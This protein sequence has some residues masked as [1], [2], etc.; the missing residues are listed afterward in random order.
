MNSSAP[1]TPLSVHSPNRELTPSSSTGGVGTGTCTTMKHTAQP[2]LTTGESL[3][4]LVGASLTVVG[5]AMYV[6]GGF[7]QY[8]DEVFNALYRLV[9]QPDDVEGRCRWE[10]VLY[11]RGRAPA[12]RN[13]HTAT[14]WKS[15]NKLVVFGGN[16]EED[17]RFYNDVFVLDLETLT[18]EQ[19]ETLGAVPDGRVRHSATIH[20]DRLYI[21]GGLASQGMFADTLLVLDLAT[22]EWHPP[23][24]FVRRSQHISFWYNKRLYVFGGFE[25]DMGRS[26]HL[27]FIDLERHGVTH[28]EI[29]SPSAPSLGGQRFSQLCGDQLVVVVTSPVSVSAME[30]PPTTGLWTLDMPSMQWT[31]R[32]MGSAFDRGGWH[33]FAM[34]EHDTSFYL[35]GS[36]QEPDDYYALILHVDLK[37]YGIVPVPPPQLGTDLVSLLMQQSQSADFSIQSSIDPDA[38]LLRA[39]RLVL[40]ARWPHFAHLLASGMAESVSDTLTLPEPFPVLEAF[41]RFLYTDTLDE[42]TPLVL[43]A[44]LLVMAN[45]YLLPRLLALCVRRLHSDMDVNTVGKIYHCAGL[46]G[47]RGLQQTALHFMFDHFG[48][49]V[50]T[51][52]FRELPQ[53]VLF[54]LWDEMPRDATIVGGYG[55]GL[56]NNSQQQQDNPMSD[57]EDDSEEDD[58]ARPDSPMEA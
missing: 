38:G 43:I 2:R 37:E 53:H 26:N 56:L 18:W 19:P 25:D 8:S 30:D 1:G 12:K 6:F 27:S 17:G 35:C 47:Q 34:A 52:H 13:D 7:D 22:W 11:T 32:D 51:N 24:P 16:G 50:R 55:N 21:A 57:S 39:H 49:V 54:Q 31:H 28:L 4:S 3:G 20:G 14:L 48:A 5:D 45:L 46:A 36:D 44:D 10:R 41:V 42:I 58:P 9:L 29:D 23:I 33:A 40:L 15:R